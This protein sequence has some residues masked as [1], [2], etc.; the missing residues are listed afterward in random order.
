MD[1]MVTP[2]DDLIQYLIKLADRDWKKRSATF[3]QWV[4]LRGG[5]VG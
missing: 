5:Y 1:S 2:G 4:I 3:F